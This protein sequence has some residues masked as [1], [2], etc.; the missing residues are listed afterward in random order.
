[1][2]MSI[3]GGSMT[4]SG[5]TCAPTLGDLS[6]DALNFVQYFTVFPNMLLSLHPDASEDQS[7]EKRS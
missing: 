6:G 2:R 3:E 1:M 5:Q 4:M 7:E